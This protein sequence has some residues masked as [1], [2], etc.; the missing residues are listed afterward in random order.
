MIEYKKL[1]Y[2]I[3]DE[4][5]SELFAY[6]V[7]NSNDIQPG[8]VGIKINNGI[9]WTY[10]AQV[11]FNREKLYRCGL[12]LKR[13]AS[14][15][16]IE[17]NKKMFNSNKNERKVENWKSYNLIEKED[18]NSFVPMVVLK[19]ENNKNLY[20]VINREKNIIE[21][22]NINDI[23]DSYYFE[24]EEGNCPFKYY[25]VLSKEEYDKYLE[26][27]KSLKEMVNEFDKVT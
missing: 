13:C 9:F 10:F 15:D 22:V 6:R 1:N 21:V 23:G 17:Y 25:S 11:G 8:M 3:Y 20:L 7:S 26:K 16:E 2:Y 27:V 19:N 4:K 14:E 12:N 5:G 18:I 24:L